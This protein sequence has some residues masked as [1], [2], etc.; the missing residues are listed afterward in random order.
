MGE[1]GA[2]AAGSGGADGL[3]EC[4][5]GSDQDDELLGASDA[6]VEQVALQ[7]HPG[8]GGERDHR[9]GVFAALGAVDGDGVGVGE[10][11]DHSVES[12]DYLGRNARANPSLLSSPSTT[13]ARRAISR[14][15]FLT[16]S[17]S[18]LLT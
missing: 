13:F 7:H 12:L 4:A 18:R 16:S 14:R 17:R 5:A 2:A 6:G 11:V 1:R 8:G 10:F 3:G 15:T 9:G